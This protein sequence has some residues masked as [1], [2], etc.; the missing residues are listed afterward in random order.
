MRKQPKFRYWTDLPFTLTWHPEVALWELR[1]A[2]IMGD[3]DLPYHP[4][5]AGIAGQE[6]DC[7]LFG[8]QKLKEVCAI[9]QARLDQL[10]RADRHPRDGHL[11]YEIQK[12]DGVISVRGP[13]L[14]ELAAMFGMRAS[15]VMKPV[16]GVYYEVIFTGHAAETKF[17]AMMSR[18]DQMHAFPTP[19][20]E[21]PEGLRLV[22]TMRQLPTGHSEVTGPLIDALKGV[23]V[24]RN[25][26]DFSFHHDSLLLPNWR[27]SWLLQVSEAVIAKAR[28]VMAQVRECIESRPRGWCAYSLTLASS[29]VIL[30]VPVGK[31]FFS[32]GTYLRRYGFQVGT[33]SRPSTT[34]M[35][36]RVVGKSDDADSVMRDIDSAI[37][38]LDRR[39][40]KASKPGMAG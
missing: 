10:D 38:L 33:V 1:L 35:F 28:E 29:H 34:C 31:V 30:E 39:V 20:A 9:L 22:R 21:L 36:V 17:E 26:P 3:L 15:L 27:F 13:E 7:A 5:L 11:G 12:S 18:L 4:V 6:E 32:V 25:D 16:S 23:P 8:H 14:R 2:A 37:R 40:S 19:D 24:L